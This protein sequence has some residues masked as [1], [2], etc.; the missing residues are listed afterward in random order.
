V[1]LARES[2][3]LLHVT[4]LAGGRLGEAAFRFVDWLHEAGQSWWQV[5]PITPPDAHGSPYSSPSAFAGWAG[6]LADPDARV[7]GPE[8]DRFR[9]DHADWAPGW[10]EFAGA[11]AIADQVRF[12]REWLALREYAAARG[13]RIIGDMPIFVAPA[14]ADHLQHPTFFRAG[15]VAGAPPDKL[16]ADGQVWGNP[17]YDWPAMRRDGYSWWIA[18]MRRMCG[19]FDLVRIDHFR[20]FVSGWEIPV[21]ASSARAGHW[22]RGPGQDIFD[23][24]RAALGPLPVIA[25]DLGR[26]TP[27]VVR[28][29]E[30][31]GFPGMVVLIW[32]F[33]RGA[34]NP[35]APDNHPVNAV[36]YPGT[37]DTPTVAEWWEFVASDAERA[38]ADRHAA[39]RGIDDR[40]PHW[41]MVRLALASRARLAILP[42]QDLLGRGADARMNRP[43]TESGN[44]RWRLPGD[45]LDATL[46]ARLAD[47]TR[48]ADR[49]RQVVVA[50]RR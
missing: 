45:A 8:V 33:A 26:I 40:E 47:A 16:S 5:L 19:L 24:L 4:S 36:A 43:G 35:Y 9:T 21:G 37:H 3:V 49:G 11:G 12:A 23:G 6:L 28:L 48:R 41:R 2:G 20:G 18:R 15:L 7:T 34:A 30:A 39:E 14:S 13:V 29:R 42:M 22:R 10:E 38:D 50:P 44:W 1:A 32:A 31:L 46:A 25:E 27:A 17:V